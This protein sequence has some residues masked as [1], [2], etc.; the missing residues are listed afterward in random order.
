MQWGGGLGG[1]K[2]PGK[3]SYEGVRFNNISVTRGWVGVNFPEVLRGDGLVSIFHKKNSL[4]N[5]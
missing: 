1:V 5:I 4:R 3:R 2:F